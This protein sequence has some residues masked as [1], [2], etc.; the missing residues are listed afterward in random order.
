MTSYDLIERADRDQLGESPFWDQATQTLYW[1]DIVG[2]RV[3]RF[4]P[5]SGE[6]VRWATPLHVSAA[7]P[8]ARGDVIAPMTDAI[9][10]LDLMTGETT[11]FARPDADDGN[12]SNETRTDPQGR[13][14]L[15]TMCNNIGPNG[16]AL[17]L[18][19]M[20]GGVFCVAADGVTT[21]LLAGIGITNAFGWSPDGRRF[22]CSDTKRCVIWSFAYDPDGP[23][24]SDRQVFFEG[25]PG[26]PDGAAMDE[27]GCLWN[28]RWGGGRI[29]RFTPDG[30]IDR[31]I[32]LPVAQP[33]C[34]AFGG[35][36]RRT[37]YITSARQE[38]EGLASDSLDGSV[39]V[40]QVDVAGLPMQR[41]RG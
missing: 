35:P 22:Y 39:F 29:I 26:N 4:D 19:R 25:G 6:I 5:A 20:S 31:E 34:C 38:L 17:D 11:L 9:Y 23:A 24:L 12:R 41:F 30:R 32:T 21:R 8:T 3:L 2:K 15:G 27:D 16:E 14:W 13:V 1:V 18:K 40:V 36:D 33:S 7:I 10:R 37:L 28:A